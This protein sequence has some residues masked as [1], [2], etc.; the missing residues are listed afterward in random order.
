MRVLLG[1][2]GAAVILAGALVGGVLAANATVFSASAFV[3]DYLAS[4]ADGHVDE[5]LALPGVDAK[6][7]D[8]RLLD[9]RAFTGVDAEVVGDEVRAG[10]HRVRV[11]VSG[12]G[13]SG[14]AVLEVERIGSRFGL[15]P[16]W[17][18][19]SSPVTTVQVSTTGDARFTAG[20]V[21]L[22]TA[23]GRPAAFAALTPALYVFEHDS[24]FLEA[25]PVAV[26]ATGT[27]A[28]VALDIRPNAVFTA[29]VADAVEADLLACTEQGILFPVGCPFGHAIENR[30]VS[31]PVWTIAEPPAVELVA[32]E[33]FGLWEV[34][35]SDGV[36][37]LTVDVQSLFDGSITSLEHDV[38]FAASYGIAFEGTTVVLTPVGPGG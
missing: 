29:I 2:V 18:F 14:E 11:A 21:P 30:V 15:F 17:G 38:P 23:G 7:L 9:E 25:E 16:E 36:A 4:L 13:V 10:V 20:G 3:R 33:R 6:G 37:R 26:L 8:E 31:E 19:A 32:S 24:Q 27:D 34:H 22:A 1:W 12:G 35:G 28:A 5:V